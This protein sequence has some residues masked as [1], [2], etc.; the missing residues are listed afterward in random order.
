MNTTHFLLLTFKRRIHFP[1]RRDFCDFFLHIKK[2]FSF[3]VRVFLCVYILVLVLI[4]NLLDLLLALMISQ[5]HSSNFFD[6]NVNIISCRICRYGICFDKRLHF[7]AITHLSSSIK[8][9][10]DVDERKKIVL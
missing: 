7:L 2:R 6:Q 3:I 4:E 5:S 1:S 8:R 10:L 9:L